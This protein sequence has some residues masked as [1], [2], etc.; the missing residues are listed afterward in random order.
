MRHEKHK[1]PSSLSDKDRLPSDSATA[2]AGHAALEE[3]AV[4]SPPRSPS[5]MCDSGVAS[6]SGLRRAG[7]P[8][9]DPSCVKRIDLSIPE[10]LQVTLVSLENRC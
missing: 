2:S 8:H 1:W 3:R 5:G 10:R 7:A 6:G 4:P 9:A